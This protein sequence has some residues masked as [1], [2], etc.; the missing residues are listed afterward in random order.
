MSSAKRPL[1]ARRHGVV[2]ASQFEPPL[3]LRP[4]HLQTI[5]QTFLR[6]KP[7]PR[8]NRE[9]IE[10]PDGDFLD[11]DWA[12]DPGR[13]VVLL[14]HG[15]E[16]SSQ[17]P[18]AAGMLAACAKCGFST[19]LMHFRGCSGE[20]NRLA[21]GYHSGDTADL[22]YVVNLLGRRDG[23][24]PH[25]LVGYSLGG[26]VLLKWLAERGEQVPVSRAAAV[27]V[28]Y[29]L[30]NVA[31]RLTHGLSR[32]YQWW[33]MRSLRETAWRK[34]ADRPCPVDLSGI[35]SMHTFREFD[36]HVTAPLH[37]FEG[38][39]DYYE[40]ASCRQYLPDIRI[41][42]LLLHAADDPFMTPDVIPAAPELSPCTTL[43][44]SAHGGHVGFVALK[45]RGEIDYWLER[46]LLDYLR[47]DT[48]DVSRSEL[49][50]AA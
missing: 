23:G 13:P 36:D 32:G 19:G 3:W 37:G 7:A 49:S 27:S 42:T 33:L 43:E 11:I 40:R 6:P 12:G 18:Y 8:L 28:P 44:L 21:R 46:R 22:D 26:N 48:A 16:G 29:L 35:G 24:P 39:D 41:R 10:L 1:R 31:L 17:S 15:L 45:A 50:G 47:E 2:A 30:N 4:P 34:F 9:R 25:A 5:W 20:P 14:L 38:V